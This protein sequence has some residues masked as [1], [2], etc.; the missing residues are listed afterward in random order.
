MQNMP[1][2]DLDDAIPNAFLT[3]RWSLVAAA[4]Q[5]SHPDSA[6]ALE[7]LCRAYWQPVYGFIRRR[8]PNVEEAQDLTQAFFEHLLQKRTLTRANPEQGRFRSFLFSAVKYFLA[9]QQDRRTALKR[10]GQ[11][12]FL[13]FDTVL[14]EICSSSGA[15]D[16]SI[17]QFD[18]DWAF[19]ILDQSL[20]RLQEEFA[21]SGRSE[22]FEGLKCFLTGNDTLATYAQIA[23]GLSM[24]E[25]AAKMTV[26]RMRDRLGTIIRQEI[27]QTVRNP[28]DLESELRTFLAALALKA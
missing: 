8:S 7:A 3:T 18:R 21:R 6:R 12:E 9:D 2:P 22:L 14:T 25:G 28:E 26:K 19:A 17:T 20:R 11:I 13:Q 27:L 5:S 24:T 16:D 10:G 1:V 23:V 4:A 15:G